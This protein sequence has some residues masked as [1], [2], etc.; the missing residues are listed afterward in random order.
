MVRTIVNAGCTMG[1][2]WAVTS[3]MFYLGVGIFSD[4]I[5]QLPGSQLCRRCDWYYVG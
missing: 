4:K 3:G 5:D 1:I 2:K